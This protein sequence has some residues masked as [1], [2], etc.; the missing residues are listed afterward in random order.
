MQSPAPN[1]QWADRDPFGPEPQYGFG[2]TV[3]PVQFVGKVGIGHGGSNR[4][5]ESFY[6][7]VPSTGDG[8]VIM[9][10][11]SNGGAFIASLLCSWRRWGA[12]NTQVECPNIDIRAVLYGTYRSKG[13][14]EAIARYRELRRNAPDKYDFNVLQL[15]SMGY[16]LLRNGDTKSAVEIFRLNVEQFPMDANVY[17]SLGE[18]YLKQG[19]KALAVENYKKSLD[20]NPQNENARDVLKKLEVSSQ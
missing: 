18:A 9:T 17:D 12:G 2:Y 14:K 1:S 7:I 3:R 10:N 4:G 8:I 5:W 20:L 11:S 16:E 15:N 6:Q 13:V 19:E